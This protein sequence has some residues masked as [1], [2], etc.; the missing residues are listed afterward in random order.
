MSRSILFL[1]LLRVHQWYKNILIFVPLMFT[2]H[3]YTTGK[4]FLGFVGLCCISSISY[5]INDWVDRKKDALHPTK[6]ERP[7]ACGKLSGKHAL[8]V[9]AILV[10]VLIVINWVMGFFFNVL[11]LT[12]FIFSNLYSFVLKHIP[13]I[14]ITMIGLNF[15]VRTL[16]GMSQL[17]DTE[18]VLYFILIF[19]FIIMTLT[20]KRRTDV[21]LLGQKALV[22]KP[23]LAFYTR[24]RCYSIRVASY[25]LL[26][27][28]MYQFTIYGRV[29]VINTLLLLGM[30]LV[31][32]I[33]FHQEPLLVMKPHYL[34]KKWY[35]DVLLL[36]TV[37]GL[38]IF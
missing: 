1:K 38:I 13:I 11:I 9:S 15:L 28:V 31:T 17:P 37:M 25:L 2:A 5:I 35:Y 12:Y 32:S 24:W 30:T 4:L 14:D 20:H 18:S 3:A 19:G 26:G 22:H 36:L 33:L 10:I 29:H 7:L 6:K 23:V 21:R 8:T 16:A 34:W 27:Y